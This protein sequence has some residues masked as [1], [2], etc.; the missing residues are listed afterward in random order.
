MAIK[1]QQLSDY[2]TS[3]PIVARLSI[4]T[5]D[6][7]PFFEIS[8]FKRAEIFSIF[9]SNI[10]PK[11][12][13]CDRIKESLTNEVLTH[14]K[15]IDDCGL[16]IQTHGNAYTLPAILELEHRVETFLYSAKSVLRDLTQIFIILFDKDFQRRARFNEV[17]K[18][19][20]D[21]FGIEDEYVKMLN[22]DQKWIKRIVDMRNAV[23]HP[24]G[25][26]GTLHID[27]FTSIEDDQKVMVIEPR[28]SL[29]NDSKIS[30]VQEMNVIVS[31]L[32]TFCEETLVLNIQRFKKPFPIQI[33][34][35]PEKERDPACPVRFKIEINAKINSF[36]V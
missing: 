31:D 2:G 5:K 6:L 36:Q 12:M 1:I 29:N 30:I 16:Q 15:S 35:I 34:E 22:E 13:A 28:W 19:A 26:S 20:K 7:L 24:G 10:Q 25:G 4:Q 33:A 32:L 11:L 23:E 27:N 17:L 9:F 3:S 21:T 18:W 8:D 14:Q